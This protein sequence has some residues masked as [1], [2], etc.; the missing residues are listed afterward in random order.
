MGYRRKALGFL[1]VLCA[2]GGASA[3]AAPC[4]PGPL[5]DP[6]LTPNF[7]CSEGQFNIKSFFFSESAG[8]LDPHLIFVT[9]IVGTTQIGFLI[10][11]NFTASQQQILTYILSYFVDAPP[12]IHG[13]QND[14]D[15]TGLVTLQTALCRVAFPCPGGQGLGTLTATTAQP[16]AQTVFMTD[17]NA[18]GLQNTLTLDGSGGPATSAGFDNKTF[19]SIP[20]P[21]AESPAIAPS[22]RS[23][24]DED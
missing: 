22:A 4:Q 5:A 13:E 1:L 19:L 11:G 8:G 21:A 6:Y 2:L 10:Q 24:D 3:V 20:E 16:T 15:P 12:I 14:L 23:K 17:I 18:I 9:P 7:T